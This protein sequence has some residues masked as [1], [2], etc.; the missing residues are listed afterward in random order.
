MSSSIVRKLKDLQLDEIN[1]RKSE[2]NQIETQ[3]ETRSRGKKKSPIIIAFYAEKGGVGKTTLCI[4]V[5]HMFAKDHKVLIYDVDSQRSASAWLFGNELNADDNINGDLN[6]LIENNIMSQCNNPNEYHLT[7]F[8]QVRD[9]E[10][11][12]KPAFAHKIRNNLFL[13]PGK[14]DTNNIDTDISN[15]ELLSSNLGA[16]PNTK[17]GKPYNAIIKTAEHFGIE[18]VFLDLN[19]NTGVLNQRLIM[20][21]HFLIV[22]SIPDF[23]C[24][25]MMASMQFNLINWQHSLERYRERANSTEFKLPSHSVK[26]LGYILNRYVPIQHFH[27]IPLQQGITQERLRV[28]QNYWFE[29]IKISANN[30][31]QELQNHNPRLAVSIGTYQALDI[32]NLV[33]RVREYWSLS[34]FA[35]IF[36][37]PVPFLEERHLYKCYVITNEYDEEVYKPIYGESKAK[38]LKFI[39]EWQEIFLNIKENI[40]NIISNE[41]F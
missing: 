14:R 7:L 29:R 35:A 24:S 1:I 21:S 28:N 34:D 39:K 4:T 15:I 8:D 12:I 23:F 18:Y 16:V 3:I 20:T 25:E 11:T 17:T 30:I 9:N 27:N 41:T 6:A 40:E 22:P 2:F 37:V 36:H 32:G 38:N 5:A 26:F 31:T 13:V 10:S 19:P 33:G